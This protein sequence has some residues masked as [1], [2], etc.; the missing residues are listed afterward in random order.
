H[1][2]L[3]DPATAL[4]RTAADRGALSARALDRIVRVARTIADLAGDERIGAAHV[5]EAIG[6]RALDRRRA[7]A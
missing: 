4:L 6:Y 7:V 1:L 3:D 2:V 5:A